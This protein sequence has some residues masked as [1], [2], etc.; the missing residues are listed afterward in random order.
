[1]GSG[2]ERTMMAVV[3]WKSR[4]RGRDAGA[5]RNVCVG[6]IAR[7]DVLK[8]DISRDLGLK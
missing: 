4:D 8:N 1:M 6:R 7:V 5:C 3:E 2:M